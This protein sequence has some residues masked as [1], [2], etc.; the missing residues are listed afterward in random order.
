MLKIRLLICADNG[1]L[2]SGLCA[3][4]DREPDIDVVLDV[5]DT[6]SL[7]PA[8]HGYAPDVVLVI[9]G[10]RWKHRLTEAA[11][12]ARVIVVAAGEDLV[13][14]T[15]LM[16]AGVRGLLTP[17]CSPLEL[18]CA[19]RMV[20]A[21]N[22]LVVPPEF[23]G[24]VGQTVRLAATRHVDVDVAASLTRRETEI[25]GFLIKG[26][27][28]ADIANALTVSPTTVR[29]HVHHILQK[30]AVRTRGQAIAVAYKSGLI[31]LGVNGTR[32]K[33]HRASDHGAENG[34]GT[35]RAHLVDVSA[36]SRDLRR[37]V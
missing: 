4:F 17:E 12:A 35:Q 7:I 20:V 26:C 23:V 9:G 11:A 15:D 10:V 16:C 19:I 27:S 36:P 3:Q 8:I 25:L 5:S 13:C 34:L 31:G 33:P 28:N 18:L 1:L 24:D 14:V 2:R 6:S 21:G 22:R 30:L 32:A 37:P 29:S